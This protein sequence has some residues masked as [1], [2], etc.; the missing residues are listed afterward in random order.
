M[1]ESEEDLLSKYRVNPEE[2]LLSQ[3]RVAAPV[4]EEIPM[5]RL[6]E[7]EDEVRMEQLYGIK[8]TDSNLP[9]ELIGAAT[10]G[11]GDAITL[12]AK[13]KLLNL[14]N[15]VGEGPYRDFELE[16]RYYKNKAP[17]TNL[18][19]GLIG[20]LVT[21]GGREVSGAIKGAKTADQITKSAKIIAKAAGITTDAALAAIYGFNR[22]GEGEG[23]KDASTDAALSVGLSAGAEGLQALG[24]KLKLGPK[25]M[26]FIFGLPEDVQNKIKANPDIIKNAKSPD[27]LVQNLVEATGQVSKKA[28]ESSKEAASKLSSNPWD[29]IPAERLQNIIRSEQESLGDIAGFPLKEKSFRRLEK[30]KS[31]FPSEQLFVPS[32]LKPIV[33]NIDEEIGDYLRTSG[34][35]G[36]SLKNV[37]RGID[38]ILKESPEYASSMKETASLTRLAEALKKRTGLKEIQDVATGSREL[39]PTQSTYGMITRPDKMG[40][41]ERLFNFLDKRL[42]TNLAEEVEKTRMAEFL[43]K[44]QNQASRLVITGTAL[45]APFGPYGMG[46][47]AAAGKY[48]DKFGRSTG[49]DILAAGTKASDFL[50]EN[51]LFKEMLSK[52]S[53]LNRKYAASHFIRSQVDPEYNKESSQ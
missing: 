50:R 9:K 1:P 35:T 23:L 36:L 29:V 14:I 53:N 46:A 44:P 40:Q 25:M 17:A 33:Q 2:E 27:E 51:K 18:I 8:P 4:Q 15:K 30:L 12:G 3:Y 26:N 42:G 28:F 31:Q 49:A 48:L 47:G 5:E 52:D 7:I 32:Q 21:P 37:R 22:S 38:E 11:I 39:I 24:S 19:A 13:N 10:H 34:A 41:N 20:S 6:N 43:S 16:E 45:G